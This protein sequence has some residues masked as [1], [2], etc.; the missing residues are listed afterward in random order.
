[1]S[2]WKTC[3]LLS[4][5]FVGCTTVGRS[6]VCGLVVDSEGR[7]ASGVVVTIAPTRNRGEECVTVTRKEGTY[8][9]INLQHGSDLYSFRIR[10]RYQIRFN[11]ALYIAEP[12][13]FDYRENLEPFESKLFDPNRPD[14]IPGNKFDLINQGPD[15][16]M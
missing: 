13:E 9:C 11:R 1:M 10:N 2:S 6:P 14:S 16:P 15:R 5:L 12:I 4:S 8:S 7:P 3:I